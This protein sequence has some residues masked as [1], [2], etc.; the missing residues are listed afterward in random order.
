MFT[1]VSTA[2][3][4]ASISLVFA[5]F[6]A[7]QC[8][9]ADTKEGYFTTNDGYRLHYIEAGSG[10]PLVMIPGWSQTAAQFKYQIEGLSDRYRVIALDM[11][12]HGESE[13][14]THG[15]RIH[16]LSKDVNEF[17]IANNLSNVTLAGHSMGCSV[18]W[19]YWELFGK[20]RISKMILIDQMPMISIN[21]IWSEQEKIDAGGILDK[22]ALWN[23]TNAL[24]GPEGIKTTEGFISGM[25]TKAYP[26]EMV[27]WVIQQNLKFPRPYAARLLFDHATNDWRD[28]LPTINIPALIVG[29]KTSLV[30]WRSQQWV[31]TQIPNSRVEI[32][33]EV[34]GGNHFMFMENPDKFNRLVREFMG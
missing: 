31:G 12:G 30:G 32:F 4:I 22:D 27:D 3:A 18:I 8:W 25:F 6:L 19:G 17:L 21:P 24:A 11:R 13:K 20:E 34:E 16:R 7:A 1:R 2:R 26:K 5:S 29:A 28:M 23:V 9:A 15:Y 14:P 33:E 10:K